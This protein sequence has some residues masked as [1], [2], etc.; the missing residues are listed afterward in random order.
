LNVY[1][2][3]AEMMDVIEKGHQAFKSEKHI[4]TTTLQMH[5]YLAPI[6]LNCIVLLGNNANNQK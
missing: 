1:L 6:K 4:T 3:V 5:S 2:N